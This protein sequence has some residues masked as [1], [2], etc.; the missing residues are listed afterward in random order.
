[1]GWLTQQRNHDKGCYLCE[2]ILRVCEDEIV[3]GESQCICK[4]YLTQAQYI[5][6]HTSANKVQ[7]RIAKFNNG[8][9]RILLMTERSY[10]FDVC[11]IQKFHHLY[12]Y[13]LPKNA[14]IFQ[15]LAQSLKA[16]TFIL[17]LV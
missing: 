8:E 5:C 12:F 9:Y 15:N 16:R 10:Y 14:F 11:Q 3:S 13:S 1:M 6:E 2:F 7:S 17:Y 4:S